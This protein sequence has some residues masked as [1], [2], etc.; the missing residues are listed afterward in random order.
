[1]VPLGLLLLAVDVPV[2]RR[3]MI[4]FVLW[5]EERWHRWRGKPAEKPSPPQQ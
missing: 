2:L 3:P 5:I 1:M 4:S